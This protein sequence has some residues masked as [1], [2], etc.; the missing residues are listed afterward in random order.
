MT[1]SS[2]YNAELF[3][4]K[5]YARHTLR[6]PRWTITQSHPLH[7][8]MKHKLSQQS[9][10]KYNY[11]CVTSGFPR[12][13]NDTF[14][15]LRCY[16]TFVFIRSDVLG[17]PIGPIFK[18]QAV[19]K[20]SSLKMG[21]IRCPETSVTTNQS[22]VTSQKGKNITTM[23]IILL[24]QVVSYMCLLTLKPLIGMQCRVVGTLCAYIWV[25]SLS[26]L[27]VLKHSIVWEEYNHNIA[28]LCHI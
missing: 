22:C 6:I 3:S 16:V 2:L 1:A 5:F 20:A 24:Q 4:L 21:P 14:G 15:L 7:H 13:V 10:V 26:I 9:T 28:R 25:G 27:V 11:I 23:Y 12:D 8:H 18:G 19:Q 17:L